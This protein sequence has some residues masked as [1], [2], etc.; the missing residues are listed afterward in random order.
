MDAAVLEVHVRYVKPLR[1][2]DEFDVHV[3]L[4]EVSRTTFQMSYLVHPRRRRV[5]DRR[6][7]PRPDQCRRPA[8][9]PARL[10]VPRPLGS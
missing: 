2:D 5:R 10:A 9:A 8:D 1:F 3:A 4:A 6:H 7:R